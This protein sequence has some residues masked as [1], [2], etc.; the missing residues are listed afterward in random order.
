METSRAGLSI[1]LKD[2][3][4][5]YKPGETVEG[6]LSWNLSEQAKKVE[7]KL[8]WETRGKG[9]KDWEVVESAVVENPQLMGSLPFSLT[10]PLEPYSYSGPLISIVWILEA[11]APKTS[12]VERQEI[13]VSPSGKE[14]TFPPV[15][16]GKK[17]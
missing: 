14:I 9:T 11:D 4:T 10:L 12:L 17:K 7:I 2:L 8:M 6:E 16:D 1:M 5:E 13:V 15:A 3:K